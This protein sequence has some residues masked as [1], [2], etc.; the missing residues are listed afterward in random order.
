MP[1]V[2]RQTA[3][4]GRFARS[5]S[6]STRSDS[7]EASRT[8]AVHGGA[9]AVRLLDADTDFAE[10]LEGSELLAARR[11]VVLPRLDLPVGIWD[12]RGHASW[13]RPVRGVAILEGLL[14][15]NVALGDRTAT[16]LLGPGDVVD[17]WPTADELLPCDVTWQVHEP[18]V[19]AILD[20]RFAVAVRRWPN[21]A[22][23]V[24]RRLGERADRLASQA[25]ALQ[26]PCVEQRVLAM[27]W[28][29][30][31]RFGRIS[32]DGVLISMRLTHQLIGQL[33]GARR[34]TV[35]LALGTLAADGAVTRRPDGTWQLAGWSRETLTGNGRRK[36]AALVGV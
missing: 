33:V 6:M 7:S 32:A 20:A 19:L 21:L 16:Q 15:R 29:L 12:T 10:H 35:T 5:P 34:P 22:A 4:V 17:P 8:D 24:E 2:D 1:P 36:Q 18:C 27:L 13:K 26:L 28:Q 23:V 3:T 31:D 25:V 9:P 11:A 14:A 30:A